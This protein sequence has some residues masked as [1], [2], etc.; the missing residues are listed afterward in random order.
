M[1]QQA[2]PNFLS[3]A[4]VSLIIRDLVESAPY[5]Q[6]VW[7]AGEVSNF[8]LAPSGHLYFSLRD[9]ENQLGCVQF[10]GR[11]RPWSHL[12]SDGE[13]VLAHGAVT[14]YSA[15]SQYQLMVDLVQPA[16]AGQL[17]L[18]FELLRARLEADG[19]FDPSRKRPLPAFPKLIG[20]ATSPTG[21]ALQDVLRVLSRRFPLA[22]VV[23]SPCLVQGE[24]APRQI[25]QALARLNELAPRPD[26]ILL[27]RGGGSAEDLACFNDELV[28]RAIFA[29]RAP[30][31]TG[32][33]HEVDTTIA[34]L[35]ADVRAPTP[36][37][38]AE[39]VT[40]DIGEIRHSLNR[41]KG[42][43][44]ASVLAELSDHREG[45]ERLKDRLR[46]MTPSRQVA[47]LRQRIDDLA[48]RA[49]RA[50]DYRLDRARQRLAAL[51]DAM[52]SLNP[53]SVLKRGYA[54]CWIEN[55]GRFVTRADQVS[56]GDNLGVRLAVGQIIARAQKVVVNNE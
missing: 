20:V 3:V 2:Q 11:L 7:V 16:G 52:R 14:V 31:V 34:D 38:A 17:Q 33:G 22:E 53:E 24:E 5:L 23:V 19:L 56:V 47:M 49:G 30:V 43:M 44:V 12:P 27:V 54:Y 39:L 45:L 6:D 41:L 35:V 55:S 15:R 42:Q 25:S 50:V 18:Q 1:N 4:E 13:S 46:I 51:A 29:S 21:A 48:E 9:A 32:I 36:S 40:P 26:V 8:R 37:V 28:A 10:R